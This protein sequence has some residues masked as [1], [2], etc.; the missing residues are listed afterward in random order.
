VR[1]DL[2]RLYQPFEHLGRAIDTDNDRVV[3]IDQIVGGKGEECLAAVGTG[4][5]GSWVSWRQVIGLSSVA[6]PKAVSSRTQCRRKIGG[7]PKGVVDDKA[8]RAVCSGY[9]GRQI[10]FLNGLG[11][12]GSN[13]LELQRH[14]SAAS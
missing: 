10:H 1:F 14:R 13:P 6:A 5:A 9:G 8:E 3:E 2:A 7:K 4:P 11:S 12:D